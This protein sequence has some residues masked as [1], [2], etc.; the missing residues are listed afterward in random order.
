MPGVVRALQTAR[1]VPVAGTGLFGAEQR[2]M[3]RVCEVGPFL[4]LKLRAF[5]HRQQGKDAFD[6]LYTL[7][8]YDGGMEAAIAAFAAEAAANNPAMPDARRA[9]E[10]LFTAENDPGPVKAAHFVLGLS[11]PGESAD[12]RVR[13][14][15][16][17]QDMTSAATALLR[18]SSTPPATR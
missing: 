13:R 11:K 5:L 3:A 10:T 15:Q 18:A 2:V 4:A 6:L 17:R 14:L 9:L 7:L 16:L 1:R 8:H 12:T